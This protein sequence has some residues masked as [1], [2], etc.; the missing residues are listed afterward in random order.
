MSEAR[1]LP[2]GSWPSPLRIEGLVEGVVGVGEPSLDGD[3]VY[4]LEGRP[5]NGGRQTLVRLRGGISD[6]TGAPE[7][8]TPPETNVRDRVH[9]YGGG[10][11]VVDRG[12]AWFSDF[13]YGRLYRRD[14]DGSIR[15]VAPLSYAGSCLF[16]GSRGCTLDRST[17]AELCNAYYCSPLEDGLRDPV[18]VREIATHDGEVA[19]RP[20]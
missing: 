12:I 7:D 5:A 20:L 10:A 16:H 14:L 4:W 3:D 2:F 17:R 19:A 1:R 18:S 8:L 11:Y 15:Q 13:T 9:E 6:G